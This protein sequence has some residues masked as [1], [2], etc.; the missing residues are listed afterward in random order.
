MERG[1]C[2]LLGETLG[3]SPADYLHPPNPSSAPARVRK[4]DSNRR[5]VLTD[6]GAGMH[7]VQSGPLC[8]RCLSGQ[9]ACLSAQSV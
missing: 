7:N 8:L 6:E 5:E 2:R 9:L 4:E 1:I 3:C